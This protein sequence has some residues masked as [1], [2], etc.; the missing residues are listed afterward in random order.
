MADEA[1]RRNDL[2]YDDLDARPQT[3]SERKLLEAER[4]RRRRGGVQDDLN[5]LRER[6]SKPVGD[7]SAV[8]EQ[9]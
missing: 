7:R 1:G 5:R 2:A 6:Q 4:H 9:P 3:F 8:W